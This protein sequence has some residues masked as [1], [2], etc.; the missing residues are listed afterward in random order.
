[1][2]GTDSDAAVARRLGRSFRAVNDRRRLLGIHPFVV[3]VDGR[4]LKGLRAS[5]VYGRQPD[6]ELTVL[7]TVIT[8]VTLLGSV[9]LFKRL[10]RYFADVI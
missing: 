3:K 1:M 7:A 10:D 4:R 6:V 9:V 8:V 5:I 2:L